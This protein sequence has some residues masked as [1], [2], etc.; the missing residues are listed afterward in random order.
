MILSGQVLFPVSPEDGEEAEEQFAALI[1][2]T[3]HEAVLVARHPT[4]QPADR[5]RE[6]L[7]RKGERLRARHIEIAGFRV[8][9]GNLADGVLRLADAED[10]ATI[11]MPAGPE[12]RADIRSAGTGAQAVARY[13]RRP[14]WVAKPHTPAVLETVVCAVDDRAA[15]AEGLKMAIEIARAYGARLHTVRAA[16]PPGR[17]DPLTVAMSQREREEAVESSRAQVKTDYE[18]FLAGFSF[19]GL[20]DVDHRLL[21][22]ERAS[23]ALVEAAAEDNAALLVLGSAGV[24]R[25]LR[26][27]LGTT[28]ERVLQNAPSS[29]LFAKY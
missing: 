12:S 24:H 28:S 26:P 8:V 4:D 9:E 22:A 17:V 3:G 10:P 29:L 18:D 23:Q 11:F 20:K 21:W 27:M 25:F 1:E 14:V 6:L 16:H 2:R 7:E 5:A 15:S 13:A 19:A